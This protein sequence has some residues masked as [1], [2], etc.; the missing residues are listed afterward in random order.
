MRKPRLVQFIPAIQANTCVLGE[1]SRYLVYTDPNDPDPA[2]SAPRLERHIADQLVRRGVGQIAEEDRLEQDAEDDLGEDDADEMTA[3]SGNI[4]TQ[5]ARRLRRFVEADN[6]APGVS[7]ADSRDTAHFRTPPLTAGNEI[8]AEE[9]DGERE[10]DDDDAPEVEAPKP[11]A[12]K[13]PAAKKA[14]AKAAAKAPAKK[15]APAKAPPAP[16]P[17][18][19]PP[20]PAPEQ[21]EQQDEGDDDDAPEGG[22][23]ST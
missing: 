13:K 1:N 21:Q 5:G 18:P 9:G 14:P 12:A 22:D 10:G 4:A 6:A 8:E 11:A 16:P 19:P 7:G 20:P 2:V 17:P 15:A 23:R 3:T